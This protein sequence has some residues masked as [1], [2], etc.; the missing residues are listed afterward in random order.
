VIR[1]P[2]RQTDADVPLDLQAL[3]YECYRN[4]GYEDDLDYQVDP[5]PPF[6]PGDARWADALLRKAGRRAYP[7]SRRSKNSNKRGRRHS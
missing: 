5:Q 1:I 7:R 3:I 4:G 2:P 6:D